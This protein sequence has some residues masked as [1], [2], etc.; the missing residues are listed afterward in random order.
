MYSSTDPQF[1]KL[2]GAWD[3][4][5]L[6]DIKVIYTVRNDD[7]HTLRWGDHDFIK[8]Y[9][10]GMKKPYVQGFYWGADGY[11]WGSDFQHVSHGHKQWKYDF[12]KHWHE[13]ELLGRLGY[14]PELS[15]QVWIEKYKVNY[16]ELWGEAIYKGMKEGS[17]II[18]AVNRLF[19]INYDFEWH[20]ESLL[21]VFGFK[22]VIDIMNGKAMPGINTF[23]LSEFVENEHNG[24]K[25]D[26]ETPLEIIEI[27]KQSVN[28]LELIASQLRSDIPQ[29]Y[30]G[31][32][33]VCTLLDLEAWKELGKYYEDKFTAA[34]KLLYYKTTGNKKYQEQA[35][36]LLEDGLKAWERLSYIWSIHYMPY[37]MA[38]SKYTFGYSYYIDN[39]KIDIKLAKNYMR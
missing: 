25:S 4:V 5:N 2:W 20:P 31:G 29:E 37:K 27:L 39:V 23:S 22:S 28:N 13:F 12:E 1:E 15:E 35:V 26:G 10:K 17:R 21:S 34:L 18:P 3:G 32:N 14:N 11:I 19:W 6:E 33:L 36:E 16:G 7:F 9:V 24:V 30:L 8:E 38:R